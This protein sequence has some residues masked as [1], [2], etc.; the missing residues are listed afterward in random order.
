M[1]E[2]GYG[3]CIL[4]IIVF[5]QTYMKLTTSRRFGL[6]RFRLDPEVPRQGGGVAG[7][8]LAVAVRNGDVHFFIS[9]LAGLIQ[10]SKC[11]LA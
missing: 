6:C 2:W 10:G 8:A 4:K 11:G 9:S 5:R 3:R 7:R 1:T